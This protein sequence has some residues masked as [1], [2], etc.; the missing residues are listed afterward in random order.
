MVILVTT[1]ISPTVIDLDRAKSIALK[2]NLHFVDRGNNSINFLLGRFGGDI[3]CVVKQS[4]IKMVWEGQSFIF[5]PN[6]AKLRLEN[7][8]KGRTDRL[9]EVSGIVPGDK[10]LDCT[11]G[12]GS[13]F[14][15]LS[16]VTGECGEVVGLEKSPLLAEIVSSGIKDYCYPNYNIIHIDYLS[17][18]KGLEDNSFDIVYFDP[19]FDKTKDRSSG[20]DLIRKL[21][22]YKPLNMDSVNEAIRVARRSV[23]IKDNVTGSILKRLNIP[24]VS[25]GRKTSYGRIDL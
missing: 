15:V 18:L 16:R 17:Y 2:H 4:E 25:S 1:P 3:C 21:A 22:E 6:I 9:I 14:M 10:V 13:D 12:M 7:L 20:L 11:L 19:M 23:V 8:K 5:H 24:V